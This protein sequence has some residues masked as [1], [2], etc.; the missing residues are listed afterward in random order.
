M[1]A[2]RKILKRELF[3]AIERGDTEEVDMILKRYPDL[4]EQP[5]MNE[6]TPIMFAVSLGHLELVKLLG[7]RGAFTSQK[8]NAKNPFSF[9]KIGSQNDYAIAKHLLSHRADP[10]AHR[11]LQDVV[12]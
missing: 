12:L 9:I 1:A 8:Q 7:E 3:Y 11:L 10:N 4:V 6:M 2:P 5:A